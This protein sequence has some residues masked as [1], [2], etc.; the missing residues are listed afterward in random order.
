[1]E[2][3]EDFPVFDFGWSNKLPSKWNSQKKQFNNIIKKSGFLG[4]LGWIR[5]GQ[6][7]FSCLHFWMVKQASF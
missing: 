6:G 5:G 7:R 3:K 4:G 2:V 1:V